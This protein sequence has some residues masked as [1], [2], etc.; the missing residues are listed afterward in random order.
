M[1]FIFPPRKKLFFINH[2]D[3]SYIPGIS[4]ILKKGGE[5]ESREGKEEVR[6]H[7]P[8]QWQGQDFNTNIF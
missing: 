5:M 1:W 8:S 3:S 6:A 4:T 7:T 2:T